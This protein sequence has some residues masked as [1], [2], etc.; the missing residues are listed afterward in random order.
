VFFFFLLVFSNWLGFGFFCL[1]GGISYRSV[2]GC[3]RW[4][5]SK[6]IVPKVGFAKMWFLCLRCI[7]DLVFFFKFFFFDDCGS[8]LY[9][10]T[11]IRLLK[12]HVSFFF[13]SLDLDLLRDARAQSA[14]HYNKYTNK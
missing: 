8:T 10:C 5:F 13:L 11:V 14:V 1:P 7:A 2:L 4:K 12:G 9:C 6:V 3:R